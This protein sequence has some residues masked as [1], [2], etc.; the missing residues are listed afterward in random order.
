MN[1]LMILA[2]ALSLGLSGAAMAAQTTNAPTK[3]ET[4]STTKTAPQHKTS[5]KSR[6]A[7]HAKK[8]D[9][10]KAANKDKRAC[11]R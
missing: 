8:L 5:M 1:R 4:A 6:T 7:K 2:S 3:S 11:R 10:T 9:C